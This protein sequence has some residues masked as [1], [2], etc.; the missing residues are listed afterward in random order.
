MKT[1]NTQ[2]Q[3][4]N[5]LTQMQFILGMPSPLT[6]C[7]DLGDLIFARDTNN[8]WWSARVTKR[9]NLKKNSVR[10]FY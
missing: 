1:Q 6:L 9:G 2:N 8:V 3:L 4:Q 10:V 5:I 7:K